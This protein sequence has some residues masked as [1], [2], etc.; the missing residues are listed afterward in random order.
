MKDRTYNRRYIDNNVYV[1]Y[2]EEKSM[3]EKPKLFSV[4]SM[5][6]VKELVFE[7]S[8]ALAERWFDSTFNRVNLVRGHSLFPLELWLIKVPWS[9]FWSWELRQRPHTVLLMRIR[10]NLMWK[11]WLWERVP[12]RFGQC[13]RPPFRIVQFV[14]ALHVQ[15]N[16]YRASLSSSL[17]PF[18]LYRNIKNIMNKG[19]ADETCAQ[20]QSIGVMNMAKL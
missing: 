14:P 6:H 5:S 19:N 17:F 18:L 7:P 1:K 2:L 12:N 16:G 8:K 9:A 15:S 3:E 10:H 11:L 20:D 4:P 13:K